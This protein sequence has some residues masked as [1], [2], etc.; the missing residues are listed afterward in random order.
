M[1]SGECVTQ[2]SQNDGEIPGKRLGTIVLRGNPGKY[3]ENDWGQSFYTV[4][5]NLLGWLL[6]DFQMLLEL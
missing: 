5:G 6:V 1:A 3:G 4:V 2:H